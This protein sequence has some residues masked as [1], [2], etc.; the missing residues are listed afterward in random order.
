MNEPLIRIENIYKTYRLGAEEVHALQGVTLDVH[1]GE[2][3]AII[4]PSGSGKSTLM[5]TIGCLD[6]PTSGIYY[7]NGRLVSEMEDHDLAR[8]RNEEIG[9]VFQ[10][11]NL[12]S[13][14]SA[15]RNVELPLV[16]GG[17]PKVERWA[18]AGRALDLVG[19][20]ERKK[21]RPNEMSGGQCQRVAVARALV[22]QPSLLLADEPT[23]NLDTSTGQ[24][25]LRLFDELHSMGNTIILVT[26]NPEIACHAQRVVTIRDGRIESD[27]KSSET[28]PA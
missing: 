15:L 14:L 10:T 5:N 1:R 8:V 4:G 28:L 25:I 20:G 27:Q 6:T 17:I 3:I 18:R 11:F 12:L 19:L 21:H 22:T 9:F 23:G 2:Y 7:L 24:D 16:Y 26:H 13:R